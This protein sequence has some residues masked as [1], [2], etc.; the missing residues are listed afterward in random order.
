L[1][2]FGHSVLSALKDQGNVV[3]FSRGLIPL[4]YARLEA[5]LVDIT[6]EYVDVDVEAVSLS[7]QTA[8]TADL[9]TRAQWLGIACP[10]P[11][12]VLL[13]PYLTLIFSLC[14]LPQIYY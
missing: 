8:R 1:N 3:M 10:C 12:L 4:F 13:S 14:H 7:R 9:N 2:L 6:P 11:P 5:E